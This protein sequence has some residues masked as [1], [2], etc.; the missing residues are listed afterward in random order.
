MTG[1]GEKGFTLIELVMVIVLLSI[2]AVSASVKWPSGMKE[3][4][5]AFEFKRAVRFAQ[6][7]AMTRTYDA[8]LPWGIEASGNTYSIRQKG[9]AMAEDPAGGVFPR[10]LPGQ[11]SFAAA[12]SVWYNGYGEPI[13]NSGAPISAATIFTITGGNQVM[14]YPQTGYAE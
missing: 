2:M 7:L 12:Q 14:V 8:A 4:A 13:D 10:T 3:K 11:A 9:G 5:A 1:C 6:H